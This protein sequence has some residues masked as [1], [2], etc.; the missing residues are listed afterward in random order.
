[1]FKNYLNIAIRHLIKHKSYSLINILGLALGMTVSLILLLWVQDELLYDNFHSNGDDIY[2]LSMINEQTDTVS[3]GRTIPYK[4]VPVLRDN[5]PE[6][7]NAVRYRMLSNLALQY[8]NK[9]YNESNVMLTEK[10]LFDIFDFHLVKG[11]LTTALEDPYSIILSESSARKIF[12]DEDPMGKV[13]MINSGTPFTVTGIL[14]DVPERSSLN[15]EYILPFSILGDS[16][17][18]WSWDCSGFVQ[19]H[20]NVDL[21]AFAPRI[22]TALV[23]HSPRDIDVDMIHLQP[24][25]HVHLYS[26]TDEPDGLIMVY[27]LSAIA[28]LILVIACINFMNLATA[29][30]ALR[31]REVGIRK[32]VGAARKQVAFQFLSESIFIT[33]LAMIIAFV[34]MELFLPEFNR[35]TGKNIVLSFSNIL[36]ITGLPVVIL[37]TG[38]FAGLYPALFLSAC[39]PAKIF[40]SNFNSDA[41]KVF[42]KVLVVFQFT[43]SIVLIIVSFVIFK[44]I[45]YINNKDLG[46]NTDFVIHLPLHSEHYEKIDTIKEK[47]LQNANIIAI[48][49]STSLPSQV[50]NVNPVS[51]EGKHNDDRVMFR[52]YNT[53]NDFFKL[54]EI[55]FT[56]GGGFTLDTAQHPNIEY[57]VNETAIRTMQMEDPIGKKFSMFGN[58]GYIVGVIEDFHNV[59][60]DQE[61]RPLLISQLSWFRSHLMIKIKPEFT[62]ETIKYIETTLAEICPGFPFS[63]TFL[64]ESIER[65]YGETRRTRSIILY[66]TGLAVFISCLGLF[67]LSFFMTQR[68][69]KEISLR[70]ILGSDI[71]QLLLKLT[72]SFLRWVALAAIIAVP[73]AWYLAN[74]F[75]GEFAYHFELGLIDFLFP[76][77]IQFILAIVTV[78]FQ[79]LRAAYANPVDALKY[80]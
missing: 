50:G 69:S 54:F 38:V 25:S 71:N 78:S 46:F 1:M 41:M 48:T 43:V 58:D 26:P 53:D 7:K 2:Q 77:I 60:L 12:A 79:T 14:Q 4:M 33:F 76:I 64:D 22:K 16:A 28:F 49:T 55:P 11:D 9:D 17:D 27:I 80:E 36:L 29:R 40:K 19:L 65:M 66:F 32:I 56:K 18:T 20:K 67:G 59:S 13:I 70:K 31:A 5:Y 37:F 75:L 57:I 6:I 68:R 34:F 52:F 30:Y 74:L 45:N 63:Y 3:G 8:D 51:W 44:Q 42:R 39:T 23:D 72:G 47:L 21:E 15:I 10:N 62:A 73:I 35:L 61:I 24:L